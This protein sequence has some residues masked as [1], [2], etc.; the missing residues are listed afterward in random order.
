MGKRQSKP[1]LNKEYTPEE[2]EQL[3]AEY[4]TAD[5]ELVAINAK[6]D[7]AITQIRT[8]NADKI[9]T[10][11]AVKTEA[12]TKIQT[13]YESKK[14]E[15]FVK[16]KS[17]DT[18]HGRIGFRA[19]TPSLKTLKGFTWESAVNLMKVFMPEYLRTKV[20]PN[21]EMLLNDRESRISPKDEKDP[22]AQVPEEERPQLQSKFA[23]CGFKVVQEETFF[24]DLKKEEITA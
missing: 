7:V 22:L 14:D 1:V 20:E 9:A 11:E 21:K 6:M 13:Y 4:A 18:L 12:F 19:S 3:V 16:R 23:E 8:K 10:L 5:S 15:M 2:I 17:I 24:I